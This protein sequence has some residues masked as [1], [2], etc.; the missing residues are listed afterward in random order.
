MTAAEE[1]AAAAVREPT[2][3][4][5]RCKTEHPVTH[6]HRTGPGGRFSRCEACRQP[7]RRQEKR[8]P[9]TPEQTRRSNLRRLYGITPEEYDALRLAQ[10]FRCAICHRH[11]DDLPVKMSGRPRLDG[12]P[13]A[14]PMK[15]HVDH[16]HDSEAIR[17]LLCHN[18][19]TGL[20]VFQD[21]TDWM[22]KAIAY[23]NAGGIAF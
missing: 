1:L 21:R 3:A 9:Q 17:G 23:V 20:G 22:A 10:D 5:S 19:N 8:Q 12:K 14:V 7:E 15:L 18:C 6:F 4:C 13:S 2:Q 16:D 11:E